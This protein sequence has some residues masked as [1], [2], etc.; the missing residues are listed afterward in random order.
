[1]EMALYT[2]ALGLAVLVPLSLAMVGLARRHVRG[3]PA[4]VAL[5]LAGALYAFGS[6]FEIRSTSAAEITRWIEVEFPGVATIGPLWLLFVEA[7]SSRTERRIARLSFLVL[8]PALLVI[9]VVYTND[10]HHL[11]YSSMSVAFRGPFSIS[12]FGRG[13]L[14]WI[15]FVYTNLCILAGTALAVRFFATSRGALRRQGA[16]LILGSLAPW[17]SMVVY[18]LNLSP[19]GLDLAPLGVS[20]SAVVF[21]WGLF[22]YGLLDLA[23]VAHRMVFEGMRDGVLVTDTSGRLLAINPAMSAVFPGISEDRIGTPAREL[24]GDN[25]PL[26]CLVEGSCA[27]PVDV[28]V[29]RDG[30]TER[31]EA[32]ASPMLGRR[33]RLLGTI[34]TL[35]DITAR[36]ELLQK[37]ERIAVT[38]ELTGV[39]NRRAFIEAATREI[40]RAR[41]HG[42]PVAVGI[43]DLDHFKLV[44]DRHGHQAGDRVLAEVARCS[45]ASLRSTDLF[46][47]WGGE[48]FAIL[49]FGSL[50]PDS[51]ATAERMRA[52]IQAL[53]VR[54]GE[55]PASTELGVTAS[56][57]LACRD[58]LAGESLDSLLAEADRALYRAKR[59]GRDR[60]VLGS[61]ELTAKEPAEDDSCD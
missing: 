27:S 54:I 1:M 2:S 18:Q 36:A 9:A 48:E 50:A 43:M 13:P 23:P 35:R 42:L 39:P 33:G 24:F 44:N 37:V 30:R 3:A 26:L 47:R 55:G 12:I 51:A 53:A 58:R 61:P 49:L 7:L 4:F 32:A 56:F 31:Y 20:L 25:Q 29:E 8:G 52:A 11:Y 45:A 38:D 17:A 16:V 41:R 5:G 28:A 46:C 60:V 6:I 40:E 10:W 21:A 14:Y 15:Y 59:A 22:R 19:Y 57:G 34:L